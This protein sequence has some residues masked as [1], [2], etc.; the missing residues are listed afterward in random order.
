M[1]P[2]KIRVNFTCK[3][4]LF[5]YKINVKF[6][7]KLQLRL[8]IS[9][10]FQGRQHLIDVEYFI[11]AEDFFLPLAAKNKWQQFFIQHCLHNEKTFFHVAKERIKRRWKYRISSALHDWANNLTYARPVNPFQLTFCIFIPQLT[12][13][14]QKWQ[15]S[16]VC[17]AILCF[18]N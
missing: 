18:F 5:A 10:T 2:S 11:K 15:Y 6:H 9:F 12:A 4:E 13:H 8:P 14:K 7:S 1:K 17:F 16:N 3:A